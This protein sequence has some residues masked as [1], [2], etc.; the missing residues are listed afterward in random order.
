MALADV[1]PLWQVSQVPVPTALAAE[2]ANV[3]PE[4]QL[5]VELWQL[6]HTVAPVCGVDLVES[7]VRLRNVRAELP[8]A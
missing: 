4:V 8:S 3:T 5:V 1:E 7:V 2:C 6:S